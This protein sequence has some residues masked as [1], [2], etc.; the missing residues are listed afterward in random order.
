MGTACCST[1]VKALNGTWL[2]LLKIDD[3]G[4]GFPLKDDAEF[5]VEPPLV[6]AAAENTAAMLLEVGGEEIMV[7]AEADA[8]APVVPDVPVALKFEVVAPVADVPD[9]AEALVDVAIPLTDPLEVAATDPLEGPKPCELAEPPATIPGEEA[10]GVG[11]D[12]GAV[13]ERI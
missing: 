13:E 8:D 7:I 4:I 3:D 9:A 10:A 2:P 1:C 5:W 6:K 11:D 12:V